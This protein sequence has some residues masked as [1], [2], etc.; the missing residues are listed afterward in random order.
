MIS[1]VI[2]LYNKEKSITSTL[3]TVLN[4]T[5]RDYE[6]VI[7]NDGSTDGSVEEVGKVHDDR[8]RLVH[9]PNAGVS[10]ARNRGVEEAKGELIAFLDADDEWK[11]EYL[12]TQYFLYQKYPDCSVFA[13]NYEFRDVMGRVTPTLI[14][15]LP[16]VEEDGILTNYFEVASCS[17]P[18]ICSISIM[19]KKQAIQAIGGFPVGVK[20]G[21]DL[22]TWAR[23]AVNTTIAYSKSVQAIFCESPS[24]SK[25]SKAQLRSGGESFVLDALLALY[26]E[27]QRLNIK[28]QLKLYVIRWYK[29]YA[30]I[31][32]EIK[33]GHKAIKIAY[34][35]IRFG[36]PFHIFFPII[37]LGLLPNI[38]SYKLLL[39]LR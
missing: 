19:V 30:V 7:V 1:V 25:Q 32:I 8:I 18:P 38:I 35:A 27:E 2:P 13:C 37:I 33:K 29:I 15:K 36:A 20:S 10:A 16:F 3:R 23:L 24:D 9:Q 11:P 34:D 5:F 31:Q 14:H 21:E 17:N 22:L 4:Q 39:K 26:N 28:R 6:I 12:A